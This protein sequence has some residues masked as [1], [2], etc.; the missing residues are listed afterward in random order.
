MCVCDKRKGVLIAAVVLSAIST[1]G[2][3]FCF[4]GASTDYCKQEFQDVAWA[5]SKEDMSVG[6]GLVKSHTIL[7]LAGMATATERNGAYIACTGGDYDDM[8]GNFGGSVASALDDCESAGLGALA[9]TVIA[10]LSCLLGIC[11]SG[12]RIW[13]DRTFC[14]KMMGIIVSLAALLQLVAAVYFHTGCTQ[15]LQDAVGDTIDL[16]PVG[17]FWLSIAVGV[18]MFFASIIHCCASSYPIVR[19][20]ASG[21]TEM[22]IN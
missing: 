21:E 16:W 22:S 18:L 3:I 1:A 4:F 12:Y 9:L 5:H 13:K 14:G 11:M 17:G 7:G 10:F 15:G 8:K 6:G 19:Y 2:T 20:S